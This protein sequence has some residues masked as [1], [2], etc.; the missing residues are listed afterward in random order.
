MNYP[1][2]LLPLVVVAALIACTRP[3]PPKEGGVR[4]ALGQ[5]R[6]GLSIYYGDNEGVYPARLEDLIRPKY[7][8]AL[9]DSRLN[10]HPGPTGTR[11]VSGVK[12]ATDLESFMKDT[13]QWVYIFDSSSPFHG[14]VRVDCTHARDG[15][16]PWRD[17]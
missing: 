11:I 8:T 4:S 5:L 16:I 13:G 7:L 2:F 1:R 6:S 9:P 12:S 10:E 3:N 14:E 15:K 17:Y